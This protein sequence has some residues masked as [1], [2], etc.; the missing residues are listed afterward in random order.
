LTVGDPVLSTANS[1]VSL[2]AVLS[3]GDIVAP[4]IVMESV[5]KLPLCPAEHDLKTGLTPVMD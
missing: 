4:D 1:D 3:L 2:D 5:E